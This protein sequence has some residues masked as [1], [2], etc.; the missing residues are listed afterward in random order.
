MWQQF[1]TKIDQYPNAPIYHYGSF[2]PRTLA[3][4]ANRYDTDADSLIERLVNVNKHIFG[5]IYFPVYSNRLK[6]I[7]HFIG[8]TWTSPNRVIAE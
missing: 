1:L 2:E 4:L 8:A 3:K 5:K 6:E 7:G